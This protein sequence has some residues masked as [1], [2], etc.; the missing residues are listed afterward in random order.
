MMFDV[1]QVRGRARSEFLSKLA[2][3]YLQ[4]AQSLMSVS[5]EKAVP[6]F[7]KA[8]ETYLDAEL[9][10]HMNKDMDPTETL[11]W[12]QRAVFIFL[13]YL[14]D[15]MAEFLGVLDAL[16]TRKHDISLETAQLLTDAMQQLHIS[17]DPRIR[18]KL[19]GLSRRTAG[20]LER[21]AKGDL[22]FSG[23]KHIA[24]MLTKTANALST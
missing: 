19:A 9:I 12:L 11:N 2:L 24:D 18:A 1:E 15:D 23:L 4:E 3:C 5:R 14:R 21:A 6:L 7:R 8:I 20:R 17:S 16:V 13:R 22:K 10:A